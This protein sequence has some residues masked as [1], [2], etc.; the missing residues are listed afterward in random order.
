MDIR[1]AFNLAADQYDQH[2]RK[3][4][5]CFDD[6]YGVLLSLA[7]FNLDEKIRVL[8]LGA[9]TGLVTALILAALPKASVTLVDISEEMLSKAKTRFANRAD[10]HFEV[11][12]YARSELSGHFELVVSA[13][14]IHHLEDSAKRCLFKKIYNVLTAGGMFINA[15]IVRGATEETEKV[16]RTVWT[17]HLTQKSGLS[18]EQ[19]D[20]IYQRMSYDIT[21]TLDAQLNWLREAGFAEVDCFYKF[22]SFSVYAGT[23]SCQ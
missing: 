14:S 22:Y 10:I 23:K 12:D 21:A 3:I 8:D 4:I 1:K 20:Q 2:R 5:P 17:R 19:L 9:G 13:M 18:K 11:I 6:F 7:P 16:C 15:E